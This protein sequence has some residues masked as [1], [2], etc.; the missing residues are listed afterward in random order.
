[1]TSDL[2]FHFTPPPI[3]FFCRNCPAVL[4]IL[5][6]CLRCF[7]TI[8]SPASVFTSPTHSP[9]P[10]IFPTVNY[11]TPHLIL[12]TLTSLA[13][14]SLPWNFA[15]TSLSILPSCLL[16]LYNFHLPPTPPPPPGFF[17]IVNYTVLD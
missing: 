11:T 15:T 6:S 7:Y 16:C 3:F 1:M 12:F 14:L 13:F 5:P 17:L 9:P 4:N 10:R 8:L 2:F